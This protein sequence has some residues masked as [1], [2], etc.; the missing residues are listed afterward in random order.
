[1][2]SSLMI[3]MLAG[4]PA[5]AAG[6]VNNGA[7][8]YQMRCSQCH[9]DEGDADGAAAQFS[10][11]RP[12]KFA[13][14]STYKIR[15]TPVGELP[16]DQDLFDI[17]SAGLGGTSMPGFDVLPEDELWDVVAYIK[18]LSEDFVDP[19]YVS[20]ALP[21]ADVTAAQAGEQ[22]STPESVTAGGALFQ[23]NCTKCHGAAGRGNGEQWDTMEEKWTKT[24]MLPA[25]L[26]NPESYRGGS[27]GY[28]I[29]RAITTGIDGTPMPSH[30]ENL[31]TAE[32]W[33]L[34]HFVQSLHPLFKEFGDDRV[35]AAQVD[36]VPE[37]GGVEAWAGV[38]AARFKLIPNIIE[39]P[40]NFWTTVEYVSVQAVYDAENVAIRMQWDDRMRSEGTDATGSYEDR[41]TSVYWDTNHPDQAALQ[42]AVKKDLTVRPYFLF[43]DKKRSTHLWWWRA[44]TD[45]FQ[46]VNGKGAEALITQTAEKTQIE[47]AVTYEDGQYTYFVKRSLTTEDKTDVQFST[48]DWQPLAFQIWN[49]D[50]GEAGQRRGLTTWYWLFLEPSVPGNAY[51]MPPVTFLFTLGLMGLL[52][53]STRKKMT[54][55]PSG[56]DEVTDPGTAISKNREFLGSDGGRLV[57]LGLSIV[58]LFGGLT[59]ILGPGAHIMYFVIFSSCASF[60]AFLYA[61]GWS[62]EDYP[63]QCLATLFIVPPL[64]GS[65]TAWISSIPEDGGMASGALLLLLF[66]VTT[67]YASSGYKNFQK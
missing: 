8:V 18:S 28:D 31:T 30:E 39:P 10:F 22:A 14:N 57:F 33:Q 62:I 25:N 67:Y 52:V 53:R 66:L 29:F 1:M 58:F 65:Y 56:E 35:N 20:T 7:V 34:T 50:R 64:A 45:A 61:V 41:D 63:M 3:A 13:E 40:R 43:G 32:R 12:R 26:R 4:A 36:A 46:E 24:R 9:G 54:A 59:G 23:E 16:T 27:S 38:P 15:R 2:F 55:Q 44:D 17:I 21:V 60:I 37:D 47:G 6:D 49:G 19:D 5:D 42:F 51:V 48:G 11:P